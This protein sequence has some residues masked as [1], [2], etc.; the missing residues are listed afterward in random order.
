MSEKPC[1]FLV[2]FE[3]HYPI[4]VAGIK[5]DLKY[6]DAAA[7]ASALKQAIGLIINGDTSQFRDLP[8]IIVNNVLPCEDL[9][10]QK[11]VL[12]YLETVYKGADVFG[13]V[14]PDTTLVRDYLRRNL[15]HRDEY[16]RGLTLRFISRLAH[17]DLLEPIV[18]SVLVN[19]YHRHC[20]VRRHAY[21]AIFA[22]HLQPKPNGRQLLPDAL[23]R[24]EHE[25][26][27]ERDAA[28]MRNAFFMLCTCARE[29]A[30]A[31]LLANAERAVTEW[32]DIVQVVAITL[33]RRAC[34]SANKDRD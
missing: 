25:L 30:V 2:R 31:Y 13:R 1:A 21:S 16:I 33:I 9:K 20:F 8:V 28:A 19:L 22:I 17:P 10:V 18:E 15:R 32:P 11:L 6:G 4:A 27:F 34:C 3:K 23:D 5:A 24:V 29:R 7:K 14:P 12:L 26:S